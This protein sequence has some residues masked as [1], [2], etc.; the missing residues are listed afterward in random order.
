M[1]TAALDLSPYYLQEARENVDYWRRMTGSRGAVRGGTEF[2][3]AAAESI[4]MEDA[5]CDVVRLL[6]PFRAV[7]Y[8]S[9]IVDVFSIIH[10]EARGG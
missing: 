6:I 10:E 8:I 3:H 4:P 2:L 9:S 1:H 5:S 7:T